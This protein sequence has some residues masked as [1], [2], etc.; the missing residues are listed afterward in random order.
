MNSLILTH[1]SNSFDFEFIDELSGFEY[2]TKV[3]VTEDTPSREGTLYVDAL[4]RKRRLSWRGMLD[5]GTALQKRRD[6]ISSAGSRTLGTLTFTTLDNINLQSD[7]QVE[8]ISMDYVNKRSVYLIEA[9][10][11]DYRFFSQTLTTVSTVPTV[12]TGGTSIPTPIPMSFGNVQGVPNLNVNNSGNENA[13]PI[14][15]LTGAGTSFTVQNI[16]TGEMFK[17][18]FNLPS[19]QTIVIDTNSKTVLLGNQNAYSTFTGTFFELTPGSNIIHFTA[20][21]SDA[22]TLLT[23]SYRSAYLGV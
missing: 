21:G 10:A 18:T 13:S 1:N 8:R 5:N 15:T 22:N 20:T 2:P 16:T 17:I 23:I 3:V 19:G 9:I 7:I 12:Q 11:P 4:F 14:F 6:L